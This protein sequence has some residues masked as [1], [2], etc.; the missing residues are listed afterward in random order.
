MIDVSQL[1]RGFLYDVTLRIE[2][3]TLDQFNQ[4]VDLAIKPI[5]TT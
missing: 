5:N 3:N 1:H 4:T 2:S